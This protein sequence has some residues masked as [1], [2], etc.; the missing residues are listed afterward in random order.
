MH[1]RDFDLN[2]LHV[3]QAVHEARNVGRAAERLGMSQ[4]AVSHA[5]AR[6]RR[7]LG[8]PLFQRAP[9]GVAPTARA[10][11][12]AR[13][14]EAA[15]RTLDLALSDA[16]SFDPARSPRRFALHMS[17]IAGEEFLPPL[18]A[19]VRRSAP[20]LH[21]E[22]VQ[23]EPAAVGAALDD[24]RVDLAIGF[25]P[26]LSGSERLHLLDER[27]VVLLRQ[28]HPLADKLGERSALQ[29]LD[30]ILVASHLEPAKA[31][32][33]LGLQ[34]RIRLTLPQFTVVPSILAATDLAVVMPRRPALRIAARHALQV[35]EAELGLAPFSVR[36]ARAAFR[37]STS[38]L[39]PA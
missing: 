25:L 20:Q 17:D 14:A 38:A 31:L 21:I 5:L 11:Q 16:D 18:M 24:G 13:Q 19:A 15:L 9:G 28:G 3:F 29:Q 27:Y 26:G 4:P 36:A 33:Q 1:L 32:H 23:L 6:L 35:V 2:L 37:A 10:E 34:S 7:A 22:A 39:L 30:F 12:F 8:D